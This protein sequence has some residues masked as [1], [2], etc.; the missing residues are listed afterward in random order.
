MRQHTCNLRFQHLLTLI[1]I[2]PSGICAVTLTLTI[3]ILSANQSVRNVT[4]QYA[5]FILFS[6]P[7]TNPSHDAL[8][9]AQPDSNYGTPD[10]NPWPI[11]LFI[12][13]IHTPH[14]LT[15][16][17]MSRIT[18]H[19]KRFAQCSTTVDSNETHW[20]VSG[21]RRPCAARLRKS[22]RDVLGTPWLAA[23]PRAAFPPGLF[24]SV[25]TPSGT[26]PECES[27]ALEQF[28][29]VETDAPPPKPYPGPGTPVADP[30]VPV[31]LDVRNTFTTMGGGELA[32]RG[33]A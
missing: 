27:F 18:L 22:P 21:R 16:T 6:P 26:F 33:G 10:P 7:L 23:P 31:D 11:N 32:G 25:F 13:L 12:L 8:R 24:T 3:M 15:V 5:P 2:Q 9:R 20:R 1:L 14:S 4:A 17:M 29:E 19:L 28:T 30:S